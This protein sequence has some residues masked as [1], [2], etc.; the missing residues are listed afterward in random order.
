M[1]QRR[2]GHSGR[3]GERGRAREGA[4][5]RPG[6]RD[7]EHP[8]TDGQRLFVGGAWA[9]PDGGHYEV[10]DPAT[11]ETVGRAPEASPEQVHGRPPF[12]RVGVRLAQVPHDVRHQV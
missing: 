4:A 10:V 7:G 2:R 8:V 11:E 9:E 5:L 3:R 6:H 1:G 12:D